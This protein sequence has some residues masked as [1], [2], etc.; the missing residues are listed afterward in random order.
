M[1]FAYQITIKVQSIIC[2]VSKSKRAKSLKGTAGLVHVF[3]LDLTT[4]IIGSFYGTTLREC[5][6]LLTTKE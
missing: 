3:D 6:N 4:L 1:R 2:P 5:D